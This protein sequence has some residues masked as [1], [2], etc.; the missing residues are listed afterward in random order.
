LAQFVSLRR[1]Q[2]RPSSCCF[3]R[4]EISCRVGGMAGYL[5]EGT[6][7]EHWFSADGWHDVD[8]KARDF[9]EMSDGATDTRLHAGRESISHSASKLAG[10]GLVAICA[11]IARQRSSGG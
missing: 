11:N 4:N 2:S 3:H 7:R 1:P 10:I 8:L 5:L 6:K 9:A